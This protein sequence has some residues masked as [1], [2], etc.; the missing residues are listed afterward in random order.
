[1][2]LVFLFH[3]AKVQLF[4]KTVFIK[5]KK[6]GSLGIREENTNEE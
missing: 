3:F 1:V 2:K 4:H 5:C 6:Y